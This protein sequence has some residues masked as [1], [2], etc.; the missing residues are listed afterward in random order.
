MKKTIALLLI[1][2]ALLVS[3]SN[4]SDDAQ[5]TTADTGSE[6]TTTVETEPA[7]EPETEPVTEPVTT[8][9]PETEPPEPYA[10][11]AKFTVFTDAEEE[12]I[13]DEYESSKDPSGNRFHDIDHYIIYRFPTGWNKN[14]TLNIRLNNQ[15][16]LSVSADDDE[17][18]VIASS[19]AIK[20]NKAVTY[21]LSKFMTGEYVY[22]RIGDSSTEDGYG[23]LI[24]AGAAVIFTAPAT[25]E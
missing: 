11:E 21:D 23:G 4:A 22:V 13:W 15:F 6:V 24:P 1:A 12:Y 7:T 14:G 9:A 16:E 17:Y 3:C 25:V 20:A 5:E 10:V 19:D 8:E 2:A 18:E